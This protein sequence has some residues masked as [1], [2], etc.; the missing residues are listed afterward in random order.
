MPKSNISISKKSTNT[1]GVAEQLGRYVYDLDATKLDSDT[2]ETVM[3]CLLDVMI[4][5]AAARFQPGVLAADHA[6]RAICSSGSA[7][8]WF[9]DRTVGP[10][11]AVLANSTAAAALDLDDG[12]R[13]ARG[14]PGAAVIPAAVAA[15]ALDGTQSVKQFIAAIV[16]GY[17]VGIRLA[18][19]RHGYA[20]SGAWSGYCVVAAAGKLLGAGADVIAQ[21]LGIVAQTGPALP[22]LAGIVGSDVKEGIGAGA[23]AGWT[24]LHLAMAG[25]TGPCSIFQDATLFDARIALDGLGDTPLINGTY[26][27]PYGCCRHIHAPL[28][29]LRQLITENGLK[30]EDIQRID[31]H[32]YHATF[33]LSN[34]PRP[35]TLV[36]AQYSVPYCMALSAKYG[37]SALLPLDVRHFSDT[38]VISLAKRTH[39]LHDPSIEPL[40]PQ[41][42]PA[43]VTVILE[44]DRQLCSPITDAR[45]D[46]THPLTWPELESKLM[47]ATRDTLAAEHQQGILEGI[48]GLR[49]DSWE[50]FLSSL[51]KPANVYNSDIR[52]T[53]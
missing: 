3:R 18:M 19:A 45:G 46:P 30:A 53:E 21:A 12:Y 15:L 4:S 31:V 41:R 9:T 16:A 14:H 52:G 36:Q 24:A 32:T 10:L 17:E 23:T 51:A 47:T 38:D 27:K 5:A 40:F 11:G 43:R 37:E 20:P 22:A 48:A 44:D 8:L 7:Q 29:A 13:G 50:A 26:F 49:A 42:S 33:N 25:F 2:C 39:V 35:A 6:A 1:D 28:D 34:L